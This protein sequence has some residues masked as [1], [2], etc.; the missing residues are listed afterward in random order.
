M[1]DTAQDVV[2]VQVC[3]HH[4][5]KFHLEDCQANWDLIQM[6]MVIPIVE[7]VTIWLN[8]IELL[9]ADSFNICLSKTNKLGN[10]RK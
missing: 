6:N 5:N 3:L 1:P 4:L 7:N 10:Q 8:Y 2:D 9:C